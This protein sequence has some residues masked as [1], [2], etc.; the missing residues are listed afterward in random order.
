MRTAYR[1]RGWIPAHFA[2]SAPHVRLASARAF[3]KRSHPFR[4]H[5]RARHH[6]GNH[7]QARPH[8]R[9]I[10]PDPGHPRARSEHH[11]AGRVLGDVERA[12]QRQEHEARAAEIP[13][14]GAAGAGE[15]GR[16]TW[17]SASRLCFSRYWRRRGCDALVADRLCFAFKMESHHHPSAIEPFQGAATGVGG[18]IR[19]IFTMGARPVFSLNSLRFGNITE[20]RSAE[21]GKKT[22][23]AVP[24]TSQLST[25]NSQPTAGSSPAWSRA[26]RTTGIA[27]A[28]RPS[29]ARGSF[30]FLG[31]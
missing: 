18:I 11:G 12:L 31:K 5:D 29:A 13:D 26:S 15:G 7:R 3:P 9:G 6:P 30:S 21:R 19:D 10:R 23:R 27:S 17:H 4:H 14:D 2:V 16:G 20:T 24:P 22:W 1:G 25:L 8:G 28:C